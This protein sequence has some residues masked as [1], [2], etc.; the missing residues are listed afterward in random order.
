MKVFIITLLGLSVLVSCKKKYTCECVTTKQYDGNFEEGV[1]YDFYY[2]PVLN[3]RTIKETK[4]ADADASCKSG[5]SVTYEP[6]YYEAQGQQPTSV[7]TVC[8]LK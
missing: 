2:E 7:L 5:N 1:I 4:K 3:S 6:G 8:Q